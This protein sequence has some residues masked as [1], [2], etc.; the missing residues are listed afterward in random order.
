MLQF[1]LRAYCV[2]SGA[3]Q[4][5]LYDRILALFCSVPY[6]R[7]GIDKSNGELY[8]KD[9]QAHL[10]NTSLQTGNGE[11]G[12]RMFD[13]LVGCS[14]RKKHT[15]SIDI[16]TENDRRNILEQMT[17]VLAETFRAALQTPVHFQVSS[18][19]TCCFAS[20]DSLLAA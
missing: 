5:Y 10:T 13:E 11:R 7:P 3:L 6:S 12:V 4:L 9:L 17:L 20:T 14:I 16:F 1:H 15:D 19:S 18:S 2:A 8:P